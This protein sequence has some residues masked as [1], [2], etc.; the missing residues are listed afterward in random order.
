MDYVINK[1]KDQAVF[2]IKFSKSEW[3]KALDVAAKKDGAKMSA[4]GFRKGKV[5]R[6]TLEKMYGTDVFYETAVGDLFTPAYTKMMDDN[7]EISPAGWPTISTDVTDG[8]VIKGRVAVMPEFKLG[9]YK[10]LEVKKTVIT[11]ED[12]HVDDYLDR[13]RQMRARLVD[14]PSGHGI[15]TGDIAVIDFVGTVDGVEFPGGA[16]KN[17]E[18]EIGSNSFIDTFETQLVGKSVGE[19]LDVKVTFPKNYHAAELAG[20]P[21]VFSVTINDVKIKEVPE[22]DDELASKISEFKTIAEWRADTKQRIQQ[23]SERQAAG[24]DEE[25]LIAKVVGETKI[26]VPDAMIQEQIDTQVGDLEA[27]LKPQGVDIEFY[28]Q[29]AGMTREQ[30]DT[31]Q[32]NMA[33]HVI[34]TRLVFDAIAKAENLKQNFDEIVTFLRANNKYI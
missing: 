33:V 7:A 16:S 23:E 9:K 18:L 21:A 28:L 15:A 31:E 11:V 32:R 25:A 26:D 19:S 27:R 17:Y 8:L 10:G 24:A 1:E 6:G 14:A 20:K 12:K 13:M 5:P 29:Y 30:F 2:E 3:E 4:P 22:L 34:K